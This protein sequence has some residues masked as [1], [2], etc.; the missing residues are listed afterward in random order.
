M[1][2]PPSQNEFGFADEEHDSTVA[3]WA[4]GKS[5]YAQQLA[6]S[7]VICCQ[8][9]TVAICSTGS[10]PLNSSASLTT[11]CFNRKW[12]KKKARFAVRTKFEDRYKSGKNKWFFQKL[13]F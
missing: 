4:C 12:K 8:Q 10:V 9:C 13:R 1:S 5:C 6:D 11:S 3:C 7:E 2:K